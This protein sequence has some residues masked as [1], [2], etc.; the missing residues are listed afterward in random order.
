[1]FGERT[2]HTCVFTSVAYVN[3]P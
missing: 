3:V 1:M 2:V